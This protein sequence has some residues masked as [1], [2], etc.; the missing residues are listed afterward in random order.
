M[1][2]EGVEFAFMFEQVSFAEHPERDYRC[3]ARLQSSLS[4]SVSLQGARVS[5]KRPLP[6]LGGNSAALG[7]PAT[8]VS[9]RRRGR[10]GWV[11]PRH[12]LSCRSA[13][14][15]HP[16]LHKARRGGR[17][18]SWRTR[19]G[20]NSRG[21]GISRG[22]GSGADGDREAK[23]AELPRRHAEEELQDGF[24]EEAEGE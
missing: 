4:P 15:P 21:E 16:A 10:S 3:V 24:A 14:Q 9:P 22:T 19:R 2:K 12:R 8:P 6:G 18:R 5:D 23:D 17:G 20:R 7:R 1:P 13:A 11:E